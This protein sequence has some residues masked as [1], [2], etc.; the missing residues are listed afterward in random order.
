MAWTVFGAFVERL[1]VGDKSKTAR[2]AADVGLERP[3]TTAKTR[4]PPA[5]HIRF[6]PLRMM[7]L[8][9]DDYSLRL[10]CAQIFVSFLL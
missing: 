6:L 8:D 10:G 1:L 9:L 4:H 7:P 5:N 3:E 2:E